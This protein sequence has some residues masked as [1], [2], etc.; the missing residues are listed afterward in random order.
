MKREINDYT[1]EFLEDTENDYKE[2]NHSETKDRFLQ[3]DESFLEEIDLTL[4]DFIMT[5]KKD[6]WIIIE[7]QDERFVLVKNL[8]TSSDHRLQILELKSKNF[9]QFLNGQKRFGR[10][11]ID[12]KLKSFKRSKILDEIVTVEELKLV[13]K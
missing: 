1:L 10:T 13:N 2:E 11:F 6:D 3:Y 12:R 7:Q 9:I 4:R 5:V 8:F